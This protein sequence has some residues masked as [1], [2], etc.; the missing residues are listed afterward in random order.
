MEYL[1]SQICGIFVAGTDTTSNFWN[2]IMCYIAK[3]PE[4]EKKAREEIAQYMS[5]DDY[6]Y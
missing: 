5:A 4:V 2:V 6:S 3:Y 1:F